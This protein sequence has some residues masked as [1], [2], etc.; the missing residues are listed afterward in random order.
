MARR[1]MFSLDVIDSDVFQDLPKTAKYL[2]F[3]LGMR[4]DDDGF[5]A[6]PKRLLRMLG[7]DDDDLRILVAKGYILSF[8]DG[9]IVIRDWHINNQLRTDRYK[10]T[11]YTEYKMQLGEYANK[12]YFI[13]SENGNQ[14]ATSGNHRMGKERLNNNIK[15]D[16]TYID[17]PV[18]PVDKS[19]VAAVLAQL[20]PNSSTYK[21]IIKTYGGRKNE[22]A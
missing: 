2:Y 19:V 15:D 6:N 20:D 17:Q 16:S 21:K 12:Q 22:R 1:R 4:A 9:V 13:I 7:C 18:I 5:I 8:A 14:V 3:E 11:I 10:P